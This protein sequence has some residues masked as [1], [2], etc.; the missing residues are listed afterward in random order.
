MTAGGHSLVFWR[1]PLASNV[2][3]GGSTRNTFGDDVR[4]NRDGSRRAHQGWDFAAPIGTP[5]RAIGAGT[6]AS[7]VDSGD[8]GLQ[9]LIR[10]DDQHE[11]SPVWAFYAHLSSASVKVGDRV[12]PAQVIGAT[13]ESGNARGMA[14]EDQ[15]LHF[16]VR[17]EAR[18]GRGLA[19]RISPLELYGTC[20][21][22]APVED[23]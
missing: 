10:Q 2:I 18:P 7:V 23:P 11:G 1:W 13:G 4:V 22:H 20:P 19:G 14:A 6:V 16:E 3:R 5:C 9:V 17:T 12:A 8:Y 21:L 15:H